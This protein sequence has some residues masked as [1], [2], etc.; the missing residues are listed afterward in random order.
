MF[1]DDEIKIIELINYFELSISLPFYI[2]DSYIARDFLD[3]D[4][5]KNEGSYFFKYENFS[6]Q[7]NPF[8]DKNNKKEIAIS[9]L[10]LKN[11]K[12]DLVY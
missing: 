10:Q 7:I 1:E 2:L 12:E 4:F 9:L 6:L 8:D 5:S 11:K 3:G